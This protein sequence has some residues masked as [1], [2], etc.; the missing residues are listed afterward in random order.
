MKMDKILFGDWLVMNPGENYTELVW[1]PEDVQLV[2]A[3]ILYN[4]RYNP[5]NERDMD[6]LPFWKE[7]NKK[8]YVKW[9]YRG[10]RRA[11]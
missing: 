4:A 6:P 7:Q 3:S 5:G 11:I 1:L 9:N 2:L 10:A 8:C